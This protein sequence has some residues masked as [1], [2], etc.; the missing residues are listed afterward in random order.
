[1]NSEVCGN[2]LSRLVVG[3]S[4]ISTQSDCATQ[5][6]TC[7]SGLAAAHSADCRYEVDDGYDARCGETMPQTSLVPVPRGCQH[8][9]VPHQAQPHQEVGDAQLGHRRDRARA[10]SHSPAGSE[11][12]GMACTLRNPRLQRP[13]TDAQRPTWQDLGRRLASHW[14]NWCVPASAAALLPEFQATSSL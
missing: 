4:S 13:G 7:S 10:P 9:P 14:F 3:E 5:S 1:M 11:W 2:S 6:A 12:H 8:D